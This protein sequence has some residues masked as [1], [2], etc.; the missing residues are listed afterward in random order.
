MWTRPIGRCNLLQWR[1][2]EHG[3]KRARISVCSDQ[4]HRDVL[5]RFC[6]HRLLSCCCRNSVLFLK[7]S[8]AHDHG[9]PLNSVQSSRVDGD[10][11]YG[12][13]CWNKST[14]SITLYW[15][16]F[17]RRDKKWIPT[18]WPKRWPDGGKRYRARQIPLT[19]YTWDKPRPTH[20]V[21]YAYKQKTSHLTDM[22]TELICHRER[23]IP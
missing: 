18:K 23:D 14:I 15:S 11:Y 7:Y 9:V 17:G 22:H 2:R 10:F 19:K 5:N 8:N 20:K 3:G 6:F 16:W 1:S 12:A 21:T 4:S 13:Y